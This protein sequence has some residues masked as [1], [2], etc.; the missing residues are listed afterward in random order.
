MVLAAAQS[1]YF[2]CFQPLIW[3]TKRA[4]EAIKVHFGA[5]Y[6]QTVAELNE[7]KIQEAFGNGHT[8]L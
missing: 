1:K 3:L 2:V 8:T 5:E 7:T 6:V 4:L